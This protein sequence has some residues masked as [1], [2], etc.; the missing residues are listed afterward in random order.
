[1]SRQRVVLI[2]SRL[3]GLG[4]ASRGQAVS[5]APACRVCP[6]SQRPFDKNVEDV[7]AALPR[8]R[9]NMGRNITGVRVVSRHLAFAHHDRQS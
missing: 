3:V 6:H 5:A 4:T 1:M 2:M 9:P 7:R 8:A